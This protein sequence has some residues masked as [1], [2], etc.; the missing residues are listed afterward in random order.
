MGKS[1]ADI[2][3]R[4]LNGLLDQEGEFVEDPADRGG[5]TKHGISLR[6]ATGIGLDLDGDGDVDRDDIIRLTPEEAARLFRRDFF[7]EP[8]IHRLPAPLWPVLVDWA[9]NSGAARPLLAL[10]QT[11]NAFLD[12]RPGLYPPL[13]E[14][15]RM[16][17]KTRRAAESA[18]ALVAPAWIINAVCDRREAFYR[19]LVRRDPTQRRFLAGWLRRTDSFREETPA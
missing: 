1:Q 19:D 14:D 4:I 13:V 5:A 6:Y 16:G 18:L 9:V 8:G 7:E 12:L 15:G 11:L 10:Q 17:P 3:A 2:V